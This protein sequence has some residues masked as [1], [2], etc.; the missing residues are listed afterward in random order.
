MAA[1]EA[2]GRR[3][4]RARRGDPRRRPRAASAACGFEPL[5][6]V[7]ELMVALP[8]G[9]DRGDFGV[10]FSA[11]LSMAELV[12]CAQ[13]AIAARGGIPSTAVRGGF[14]VVSDANT[15]AAAR[16]AY[17]NGGPFLVGRGP[18]LD[19]MIDAA[20]GRAPRAKAE[21]DALRT[22]LSPAGS[23][24]RPSSSPRLPK[25]LR[26]RVR[27]D[28][29]TGVDSRPNEAF[30]GVLGVAEAGGAITPGP[31]GSDGKSGPTTE[32]DLELRCETLELATT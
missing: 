15:P 2:R 30:A 10:A 8:E 25:S 16:L 27:A 9:G 31:G 20:D 32:V 29:D 12:A 18:W 4:R 17:R 1:L 5:E 7:R 6:H 26:D 22:A 14:S 11:D 24:P 3:S 28:S 23:P 13:K 21:H 19:A